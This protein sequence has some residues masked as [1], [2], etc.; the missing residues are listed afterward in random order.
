MKR[1]FYFDNLKVCLTVLVIFHH[2]GEASQHHRIVRV[3][4]AATDDS[5]CKEGTLIKI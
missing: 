5:W 1:L 3:H 4:L 2:A